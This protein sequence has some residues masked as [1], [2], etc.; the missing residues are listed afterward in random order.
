MPK[1]ALSCLLEKISLYLKEYLGDKIQEEL[2]MAFKSIGQKYGFVSAG[3]VYRKRLADGI[4]EA[5]VEEQAKAQKL[6][7]EERQKAEKS[8]AEKLNAV[9]KM[10]CDGVISVE[11]AMAYFGYSKEQILAK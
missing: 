9:K 11:N 10:V 5:R 7:A 3:D 4:A 1:E 2:D 6:V 8:E